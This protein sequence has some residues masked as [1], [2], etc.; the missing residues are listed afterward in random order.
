MQRRKSLSRRPPS[1]DPKVVFSIVTEGKNTEPGYFRELQRRLDSAIIKIEVLGA[2]GV[3]L[4]ISEIAIEM[5]SKARRPGR[6]GRTQ[7]FETNDEVWAVFDCDEHPNI[8]QATQNCKSAG[9]GVAFS[10][11]CFELWLILHHKEF[12]QF[13]GR[14]AV[15]A[16]CEATCPGYRKNTR[17]TADFEALMDNIDIAETRA[18]R[19]YKN[20][21]NEAPPL[22][23]PFTTV[24]ELTKRI[25]SVK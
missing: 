11:P 4:T 14:H 12:D 2:A 9:V 25:R 1:R 18:A 16:E 23:P 10:N 7:S 3:P 22:N 19:Q 6:G 24:F 8:D 5:K 20:R 13:V 21:Q 17:K 15:Q